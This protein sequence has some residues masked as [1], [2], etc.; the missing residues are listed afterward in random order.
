VIRKIIK[1]KKSPRHIRAADPKLLVFHTEHRRT[2][3]N[4]D[5]A[6]ERRNSEDDYQSRK[7]HATQKQKTKN[8]KKNHD[9]MFFLSNSQRSETP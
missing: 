9:E 8:T 6:Q 7:T 1:A 2:I 4:T 3:Y 5:Y